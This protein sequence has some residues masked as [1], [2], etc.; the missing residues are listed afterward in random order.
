M[1][2]WKSLSNK[3]DKEHA[4]KN[5]FL[6]SK[7]PHHSPLFANM[8]PFIQ[9]TKIYEII[10]YLHSVLVLGVQWYKTHG[11]STVRHLH[12][13]LFHCLFLVRDAAF[14]LTSPVTWPCQPL[15]FAHF[16]ELFGS[17]LFTLLFYFSYVCV[18]KQITR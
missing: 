3:N 9:S 2:S 13:S 8:I 11:T 12:W 7:G 1:F 10:F 18:D 17:E 16:Q 4:W 5:H 15:L 14:L 6:H